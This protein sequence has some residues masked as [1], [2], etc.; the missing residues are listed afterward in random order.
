[1]GKIKTP[2]FRSNYNELTRCVKRAFSLAT[3]L[4][5][6]MPFTTDLSSNDVAA[7]NNATA[8]SF[9]VVF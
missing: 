4:K 8:S 6:K 9:L 2:T 3:V 5:W 1:M 7:F